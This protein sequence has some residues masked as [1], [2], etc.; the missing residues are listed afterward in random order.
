MYLEL[1][2][3]FWMIVIYMRVF[4]I[5]VYESSWLLVDYYGV[6]SVELV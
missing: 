4:F 5:N 3:S 6:D 2:V 1:L